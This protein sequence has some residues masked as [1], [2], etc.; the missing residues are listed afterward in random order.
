ML[1]NGEDIYSAG[2]RLTDVRRQ[3]G[4]VFQ[5]PNPFPAM[6]VAENVLAGLTLTKTKISRSERS[7]LVEYVP[8]QGRALVRGQGP[9]RPTRVDSSRAVSSN[10]SASPGLLP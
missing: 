1:L 9:A 2:N 7:Q 3:I 6:S 8:D 4:M 10:G 5:K